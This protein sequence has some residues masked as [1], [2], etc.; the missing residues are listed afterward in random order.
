MGTFELFNRRDR[1]LVVKL[2]LVRMPR[3]DD[4]VVVVVVVMDATTKAKSGPDGWVEQKESRR[5][6]YS[7]GGRG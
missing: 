1:A 4:V 6:A 7:R 5:Q 3:A 2:E